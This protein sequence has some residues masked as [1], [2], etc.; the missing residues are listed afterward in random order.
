MDHQ[1]EKETVVVVSLQLY[2]GG[3]LDS[4]YDDGAVKNVAIPKNPW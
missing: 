1:V 2:G 3:L 4:E